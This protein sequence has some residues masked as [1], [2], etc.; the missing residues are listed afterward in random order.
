MYYLYMLLYSV[1]LNLN[2][3]L[4]GYQCI[5]RSTGNL[6]KSKLSVKQ[7]ITFYSNRLRFSRIPAFH[8]CFPLKYHI[9]IIKQ[10]KFFLNFSRLCCLKFCKFI[11]WY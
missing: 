4:S 10:K 1:D 11:N 6:E 3:I 7:A 2:D 5:L 8:C 9:L